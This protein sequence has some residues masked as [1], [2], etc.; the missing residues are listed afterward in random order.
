[1]K[2]SRD[3]QDLALR[4]LIIIAGVLS[5]VLMAMKGQAHALPAL[6]IGAMLGAF[7]I[8]SREQ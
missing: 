7:A 4:T 1:M 6:A 2:H 8:P 3:L 5:A